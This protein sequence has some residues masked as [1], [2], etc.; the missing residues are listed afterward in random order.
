MLTSI[1]AGIE[2]TNLAVVV[3][4]DTARHYGSGLLDV[5]ATPAMISIMEKTAMESVQEHLASGY[6]TVGI[7]INIKHLKASVVG[8][9]IRCNSKLISVDG[10]RLTFKVNVFSHDILIGTGIHER[11][12]IVEKKF[13]EN[14]LA[15]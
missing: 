4:T 9:K 8:S 13:L 1:I 10:M 12:I 7:S 15:K 2:K 5:Y 14:I 3:K 6:G 11:Y